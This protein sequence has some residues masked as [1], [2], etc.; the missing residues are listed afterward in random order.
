MASIRE[1]QIICR[2]MS[3]QIPQVDKLIVAANDIASQVED[4][5]KELEGNHKLPLLKDAVRS[6]TIVMID[7][8]DSVLKDI[9]M[10]SIVA[11][12]DNSS[13]VAKST[14]W[15]NKK[16]WQKAPGSVGTSSRMSTVAEDTGGVEQRF[17]DVTEPVT[18]ADEA[19]AT[20]A[21]VKEAPKKR[22]KKVKRVKKQ[23]D[24]EQEET[25]VGSQ[26]SEAAISA[27]KSI[28][29]FMSDSYSGASKELE[30]HVTNSINTGKARS[31]KTGGFLE[32]LLALLRDVAQTSSQ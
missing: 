8:R 26:L 28:S 12:G 30:E 20:E 5:Y 31:R 6:I 16:P 25:V 15:G 18:F 23:P 10:A 22:M 27:L 9:V 11:A 19:T 4:A 3:A 29:Y 13:K 24:L 17:E 21:P 32:K 7:Y 1:M 14:E 2:D